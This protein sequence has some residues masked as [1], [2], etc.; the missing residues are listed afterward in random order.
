V[1]LNNIIRAFSEA[2]QIL[3]EHLTRT[4]QNI[5]EKERDLTYKEDEIHRMGEDS[6]RAAKVLTELRNKLHSKEESILIHKREIERLNQIVR[7]T[8]EKEDEMLRSQEQNEDEIKDLISALQ[9]KDRLLS[10]TNDQLKSRGRTKD[11]VIRR[12][13]MQLDIK[14]EAILDMQSK[15]EMDFNNKSEENEYLQNRIAELESQLMTRRRH[16][17]DETLGKLEREMENYGAELKD[18]MAQV[19][20]LEKVNREKSERIKELSKTLEEMEEQMLH[21]QNLHNG[22]MAEKERT[23]DILKR[24][25]IR[26]V[27]IFNQLVESSVNLDARSQ[28]IQSILRPWWNEDVPDHYVLERELRKVFNKFDTDRD[29]VMQYEEFA[30]AWED[31]GLINDSNPMAR[32]FE[33][34]N[35]NRNQTIEYREFR[36]A[37]IAFVNQRSGAKSKTKSIGHTMEALQGEIE[38]LLEIINDRS[39]LLN[40]IIAAKERSV[41]HKQRSKT[42]VRTVRGNVSEQKQLRADARKKNRSS[43]RRSH[44]SRDERTDRSYRTDT[45]SYRS[46]ERTR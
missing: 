15:M 37:I 18:N 39:D 16:K 43:S 12:L 6:K 45:R 11:D 28:N 35:T 2:M 25:E 8:R 34:V 22:L 30:Q 9:E 1:R 38:I 7:E 27:D 33:K 24:A 17:E 14:Q 21:E 3:R 36:D 5:H 4:T 41:S 29:G 23:L 13:E 26:A 42:P 44:R 10:A 19:K 31:L 20:K 40:L 46:A 32:A